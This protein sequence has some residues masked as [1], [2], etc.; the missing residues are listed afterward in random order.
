MMPTAR[1]PIPRLAVWKVELVDGSTFELEA[2]RL[3][4]N[5]G[6]L[7]FKD[8]ADDY[9]VTYAPG[10]WKFCRRVSFLDPEPMRDK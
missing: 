1:S 2:H 6:A 5:S 10:E 4:I 3:M 7:G 8:K 9:F